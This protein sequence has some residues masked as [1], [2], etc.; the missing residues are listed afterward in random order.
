MEINKNKNAIGNNIKEIRNSLK[1]T[2]KEFADKI[3]VSRP[4]VEHWENNYTEPDI[5]ALKTIKRI[6][7]VSYDEIIDGI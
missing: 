4:T 5:T 7:N 6:F 2:Q 3:G 1:L